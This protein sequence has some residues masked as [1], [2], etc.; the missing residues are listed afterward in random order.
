MPALCTT[1][2][3]VSHQG[4]AKLAYVRNNKDIGDC[5][6]D[7]DYVAQTADAW[8]ATNNSLSSTAEMDALLSTYFAFDSE[9]YAQLNGYMLLMFVVG[10]AVGKVVNI[11]NISN[12]I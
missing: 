6:A 12:R 4:S 7:T 2:A 5:T 10:F 9:L 3:V 1:S 11:L 8:Q